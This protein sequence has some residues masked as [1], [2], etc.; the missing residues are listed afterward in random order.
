MRSPCSL[1]QAEQAQLPQS[2]FVGEVL[3][4][5]HHLCGPPLDL[6]QQLPVFLELVFPLMNRNTLL[7]KAAMEISTV[8]VFA[9]IPR[10][11]EH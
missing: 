6:L 2:V 3:Q 10:A 4:P 11:Q 8:S 5:S 1:L 9:L 7:L